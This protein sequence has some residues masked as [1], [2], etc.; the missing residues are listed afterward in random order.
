M[1]LFFLY[2]NLHFTFEIFGALAFF[3][4]AWLAIDAFLLQK[5]NIT[6]LRIIG[7]SLLA[8]WQIVHAFNFS[9]ELISYSAYFIYLFALLMVILSFILERPVPKPEFKAIL[10]LP[11]LTSVLSKFN[12]LVTIFLAL[13]TYLTFRQYTIET[14]KSLKP[15]WLG[16]FFLSLGA[17]LAI[18]YGTNSSGL[19]WIMG[20]ALQVAGFFSLSWWVWQY[21]HLRIR[22]EMTLI[23]VSMALIMATLITLAFS[24]ILV[25]RIEAETKNNLI[26]NSRVLDFAIS[27]LKEEALAKT[28]LIAKNDDIET[29]MLE[30]DFEN[31]ENLLVDFLD[32]ENLGFLMALDSNGSVIIRAHGLTKKNDNLSNER[33]V[34]EA[35]NARHFITIESSPAEGFSI[36]A[37]SPVIANNEVLGIIV[38]GFPMDNALVDNIKKL[39]GLE[40]S[41]FE[42]DTRVATTTINPD[43]RTRSTGIKLANNEV[44]NTVLRNSQPATERVE[45]ISRS[46][47]ASYLPI[48]NADGETVGMI[49]AAKPQQELLETANATN[50]LTFITVGIIVLI[51]IVPIYMVTRRLEREI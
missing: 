38:A 10:V 1:S 25:S 26:T 19:I 32:S 51:L 20:H 5:N 41:I 42:D 30:S 48:I 43:G 22:E 3:T 13:I 39:T 21:L 50:R 34:R 18:I 40:M 7:F 46:F 14:K 36:R 27:G 35:L 12:T 24:T 17:A 33:A 9:G 44:I 47:L 23:F 29:A 49:S 8:V 37:A 2:N 6:M 11:S 16:F 45:I 15:F 31:L 28:K 4:M